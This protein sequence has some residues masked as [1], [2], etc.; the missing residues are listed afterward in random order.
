MSS[1]LSLKRRSIFLSAGGE[2]GRLTRD[3]NW[4]NTSIG[5]PDQWPQSLL[6]T[7]NTLLNSRYP[8]FLWWG[9]DLIQFY[10]DAY[11]PS[12]GA[13]GKHPSALGAKG[14]DT[15]SEIWEVIKPLIDNV[16]EKGEASWSEDQLIPIY[17]NNHLENVYWT[18]SYSPV[19]DDLGERKGVLVV[20]NETTSKVEALSREK[21][22]IID[23]QK[24]Q[25]N[26]KIEHDRFRSI[27]EQSPVALAINKGDDLVFDT[28]NQTMLNLI[29]R[30]NSIIGKS[31]K[32]AIPE[33]E[34]Q[35]VLDILYEA[36][37][38]GNEQSIF[39]EPVLLKF[40]GKLALR[41][42]NIVCKP[43]FENNKITGILQSVADVTDIIKNR[44]EFK[45]TQD[46]LVLALQAAELGTF[47][48]D[49]VNNTLHWDTR[50]RTLFGISH[51]APVTY[52]QNFVGGLHP[53]DR[54]RVLKVIDG[55][56]DKALTNG[57]YDVEFR[58]VGIED[59]RI[60]WIRAKGKAY[61]DQDDKP[62]RFI[63]TALDITEQ[64]TDEIRKNDFIG[65]VSHELKT[66]LT[67]LNALTQVLLAKAKKGDDQF[68]TGALE[69]SN[70]QVKKMT[71]LINGFLNISR[72]ESGK[73]HLNKSVFTLN[74]LINESIDDISFTVKSHTLSFSPCQ[75]IFVDADREKIA[76]VIANFL[77]NAIKYS[78]NGK[79]IV[80]T[81]N[82][83][84]GEAE[85]SVYDEGMGIKAE[86]KEKIFERY[87]R[88]QSDRQKNISGFGIG[89]YLSAEII[90][91]HNGRV[92]VDSEVGKGSRFWFKLPLKY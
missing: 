68:L 40:D 75:Q 39:E 17:R 16:L 37:T 64:K 53:D 28:V 58:T 62:I 32:D 10:N 5:S 85:V 73:I 81:C 45:K 35:P 12:L 87:Y 19:L 60:R 44:N 3:Y 80:V 38:T 92:G 59:G 50:C 82:V 47:D 46:S 33:L 71:D 27:F 67:I 36:Y 4:A 8:M 61:F 51:H 24:A 84:N 26:L 54:D 11:R 70:N 9:D 88:V 72:L 57:D 34:G 79:N 22:A 83:N 13:D 89:L 76:S 1:P 52:E 74:D 23:L 43:F 86:D 7:I 14:Y 21:A 30:G 29:G 66:P 25:S 63:G 49:L 6:T 48:V 41:Y 90:R 77:N 15:W 78:P 2:M 56:F 42:F 20:C 65:M 69:K 18:F 91:R 55:V 31:W